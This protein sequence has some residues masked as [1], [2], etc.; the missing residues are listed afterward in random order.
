MPENDDPIDFLKNRM[1]IL[2]VTTTDLGRIIGY[3]SRA[4]EILS[5][6][7]KMTLPMMRKI[8]AHLHIPMGILTK[9]YSLSQ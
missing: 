9:E 8:H 4:S 7:R 5:R 1:E 2:Q 3:K 6:K